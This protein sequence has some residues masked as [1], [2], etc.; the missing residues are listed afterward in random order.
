VFR[1][2]KARSG[3]PSLARAVTRNNGRVATPENDRADGTI[4][5]FNGGTGSIALSKIKSSAFNLGEPCIVGVYA[6]ELGHALGLGHHSAANDAV[7][8]EFS[9][10]VNQAPTSVDSGPTPACSGQDSR[11]RGVKC[12][13]NFNF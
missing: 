2:A 7:M 3:P 1:C 6:H 10:R 9:N 8:W 12:I 11:F 4:I 5:P 13:Y